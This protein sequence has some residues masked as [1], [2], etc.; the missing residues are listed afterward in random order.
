MK[1]L[2]ISTL[3]GIAPRDYG[4]LVDSLGVRHRA[5]ESF[6]R[7]MLAGHSALPAMRKGL[8]HDNDD[9]RIA[10]CRLLDH[11]MD[12]KALPRL[13]ENLKH[14]SPNVRGAAMHA[15]AC[16]RCKEGA[17]RPA[18]EKV[19]PIAIDMLLDDPHRRVRQMA[20]DLLGPSVHRSPDVL[21]ALVKA[22]SSDTSPTV[23]KIAGWWIPGGVR[24]T[25]TLK[26]ER[27]DLQL[28]A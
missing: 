7:L 26:K 15:L 20:A 12:V 27:S 10:C 22:N 8:V 16:D 17:C 18:E 4:A 1:R 3:G 23:R 19:L 25:K 11:F 13:I 5:K 24:Y 6:R 14:P 2:R 21:G 9:V 28:S